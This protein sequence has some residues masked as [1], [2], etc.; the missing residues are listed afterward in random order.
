MVVD[1][2][3]QLAIREERLTTSLQHLCAPAPSTKG[4]GPKDRAQRLHAELERRIGIATKA[5]DTKDNTPGA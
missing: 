2:I 4:M 3:V 5:I 1:P